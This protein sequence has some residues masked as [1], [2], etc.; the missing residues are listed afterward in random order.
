MLNVP[1]ICKPITLTQPR[2]L[3]APW[4]VPH[5]NLWRA[6]KLYSAEVE[7]IWR[8]QTWSRWLGGICR[9]WGYMRRCWSGSNRPSMSP[10]PR[11]LMNLS[12]CSNWRTKVFFFIF[13]PVYCI[14]GAASTKDPKKGLCL[15]HA[16]PVSYSDS[17]RA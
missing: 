1:P 4:K 2:G 9:K 16:I 11:Q 3:E 5:V 8:K 14:V 17:P 10:S 13:V 7:N 6:L 15:K 12:I